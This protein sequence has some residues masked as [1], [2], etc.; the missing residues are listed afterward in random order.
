MR[1]CDV[2]N[3]G[4]PHQARGLCWAHYQALRRALQL[5]G[6]WRPRQAQSLCAIDGCYRKHIGRGFCQMHYFR[7]RRYGDPM[8]GGYKNQT[9]NPSGKFIS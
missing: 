5:T 9:W 6:A 8:R 2:E 1:K 4:K 7:W 3:C